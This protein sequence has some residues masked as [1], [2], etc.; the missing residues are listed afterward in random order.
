MNTETK[1][2]AIISNEDAGRCTATCKACSHSHDLAIDGWNAFVCLSCGAEVCRPP[3]GGKE[4][5]PA[6]ECD[7]CGGMGHTIGFEGPKK[8]KCP[9]ESCSGGER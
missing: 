8:I 7:E 1:T 4:P 6:A 9:C 2:I 5:H 3:E